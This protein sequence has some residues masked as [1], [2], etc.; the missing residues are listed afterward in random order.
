MKVLV[1]LCLCFLFSVSIFL[2]TS[3]AQTQTPIPPAQTSA[4][5]NGI[6]VGKAKVFDNRSLVLM[7]EQLSQTLQSA[8]AI[9][10]K[11][12]LGSIGNL[13]GLQQTD[14]S[15]GLSVAASIGLPT[16]Q[17]GAAKGGSG[18]SGGSG[19]DD[20]V[21]DSSSSNSKSS[22]ESGG[23]PSATKS[24][25]SG[26]KKDTS[27]G[28]S[29]GGDS[30]SSS[31]TNK[32]GISAQDLLTEQVALTYQIYNL[33]LL[34]E[35]AQT[36]RI[37][38]N[39][40]RLQEVIGFNIS[41]DP[42]HKFENSVAV[43]EVTVTSAGS[44]PISLVSL[45]PNEK[46][47]N[48]AAL[49]THSNAFSGAVAA[50][51]IQVGYTEKHSGKTYFLYK[52]SD[53]F[54][55]ERQ[56]HRDSKQI[57]FG[58]EFRPVLGRKSVQPGN[59]QVFAVLAL[60]N[61]TAQST[62]IN[63][64]V[65]THWIKFYGNRDSAIATAPIRHS[66]DGD[67]YD[68]FVSSTDTAS[69]NLRAKITEVNWHRIG[70]DGVLID[71]VGNNF[72][73][74]TTA[75]IGNAVLSN[76]ETGLLLKSDQRLQII[77]TAAAFSGSDGVI[78]GR[79][80]PPVPLLNQSAEK[81]DGKPGWGAQIAFISSVVDPERQRSEIRIDL[82]AACTPGNGQDLSEPDLRGGHPLIS[83]GSFIA[84]DST[85]N[86]PVSVS[87]DQLNMKCQPVVP[88]GSKIPL[89]VTANG[90][91]LSVQVP[92]TLLNTEQVVR[93]RVPFH[94]KDFD[95]QGF[96]YPGL[97]VDK[98][99]RSTQGD[100]TS[101]QFLGAG[102]DNK[103]QILTAQKTYA[104][105]G[106]LQRI[107]TTVLRLQGPKAELGSVTE[108]LVQHGTEEPIVVSTTGPPENK[109]AKFTSKSVQVPAQS[110]RAVTFA[111]EN[112]T[113]VASVRFDGTKLP[114]QAS[115]D[116]KTLTV[117]L[118]TKVTE[119]SGV[120]VEL[121]AETA[122]GSIIDSLIVNVTGKENSNASGQ[123]DKAKQ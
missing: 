32:Y 14:I 120:P 33:R 13:Q 51:V 69:E 75:L 92:K 94:G 117:H 10:T 18:A 89:Q 72:Y 22:S 54:A 81:P 39:D 1:T 40:P 34:L 118:G 100:K 29:S 108:L 46:T 88:A 25:S 98:V 5:P 111:G 11:G 83:I 31:F 56:P 106:E 105:G 90:L 52:D 96:I 36:D 44:D 66:D 53:T 113:S 93:V 71:A 55:F 70:T 65:K 57:T 47:Y 38:G 59:R 2:A 63:V 110:V 121:L 15:R 37:Y 116:G 84:D 112:L 27:S 4:A 20:S 123:K 77:T 122:S 50:K 17:T 97:R 64:A 82:I 12:L 68:L 73:S 67:N 114:S 119:H 35:R 60:P 30:S 8:Q 79:Y 104:V 103:V 87:T 76:P 28:G 23:T 21:G 62:S 91:R 16:A 24:D 95:S 7:L 26:S 19:G 3:R 61:T 107:G 80:G 102:F 78:N 6:A 99:V 49:D 115:T 86:Q 41:I 9:D 101:L 48:M 109:T 85:T 43:V 42:L 74:G 58:W 45:L